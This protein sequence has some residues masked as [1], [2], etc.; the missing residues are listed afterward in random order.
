MYEKWTH[1]RAYRPTPIE[2][3]TDAMSENYFDSPF[4]KD[5]EETYDVFSLR[6]V[7]M[8]VIPLC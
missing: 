3:S 5:L 8:F 4:F 7:I 2:H 6:S 1:L